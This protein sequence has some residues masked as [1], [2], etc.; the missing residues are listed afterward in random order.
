MPHR[1]RLREA[2]LLLS[3]AAFV[4]QSGFA[5][6]AS[7]SLR[8]PAASAAMAG[9]LA[10]RPYGEVARGP[11]PLRAAAF[12][13]VNNVAAEVSAAGD[14][15]AR[16]LEDA[17]L[18]GQALFKF[19][20]KQAAGGQPKKFYFI[21]AAGN[22]AA[23]VGK[24][25]MQTLSYVPSPDGD[26][27][28][29][30]KPEKTYPEMKS[31]IWISDKMVAQRCPISPSDFYLDNEEEYRNLESQVIKEFHELEGEGEPMALIVGESAILRQENID[32]IKQGL[33]IWLD[34]DPKFSW[35]RTQSP[36]RAHGQIHIAKDELTRPPVWALANGWD[37]DVD[38]QESQMEY[39]EIVN[40]H[41]QIYEEIADIRMR[42]DNKG[43]MENSFWGAER[44]VKALKSFTGFSEETEASLEGEVLEQDLQRFL[45]G[46]RLTKYLEAAMAWCEEQ[47]AASIEDVIE[48]APDF[49]EA[50]KLKPLEKKRLEKAAAAVAVA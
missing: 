37:G 47:G 7:R 14:R 24:S 36:V 11:A 3:A 27:L 32:I 44:I 25:V 18:S 17:F 46:A 48:N 29:D 5:W 13:P 26:L 2:V 42:T 12:D 15:Y 50:L 41:Q 21:G 40:R 39:L 19:L 23:G 4:S 9:R 49:A 31:T 34:V 10:H 28:L 38:D 1:W 33:V 16:R 6:L 8:Q 45:E 35:T 43:I 30:R 22:N 20:K